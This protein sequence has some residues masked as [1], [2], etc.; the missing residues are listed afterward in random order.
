[1]YVA[2][3]TIHISLFSAASDEGLIYRVVRMYVCMFV[4]VKC[5]L[6]ERSLVTVPSLH[7]HSTIKISAGKW[8]DSRNNQ[9]YGGG[10][11][12]ILVGKHPHFF[13]SVLLLH[14]PM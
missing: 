9:D 12:Q 6:G 1:M 8:S 11:V 3:V 13:G 2:H 5:I 7:C 4:F 10:P 14:V